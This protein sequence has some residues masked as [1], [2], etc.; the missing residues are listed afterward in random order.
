MPTPE[1]QPSSLDDR[2]NVRAIVSSVGFIRS[3]FSVLLASEILH[4]FFTLNP[5]FDF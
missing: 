5:G 2:V 4:Q 3:F 1:L